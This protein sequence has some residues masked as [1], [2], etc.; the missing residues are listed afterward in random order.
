MKHIKSLES[1]GDHSLVN[2]NEER[3]PINEYLQ[4]VINALP[5]LEKLINKYNKINV[6]LKAGVTKGRREDSITIYS[7]DLYNMLSPL[8]KSVFSSIEISFWGGSVTSDG[9]LW[10]NPK[11]S[12]THP[13][14]GR[15]G[16]DFIWDSLWFDT[17]KKKWIEGR[18]F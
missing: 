15:N 8:G 3:Q 18:K 4:D 17:Q 6:K 16:T 10:F 1:F 14:R 13:S 11:V 5:E 9:N 2:E 7:D 12:Y